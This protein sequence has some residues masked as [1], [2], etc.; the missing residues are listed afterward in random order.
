MSNGEQRWDVFVSHW[1]GDKEIVR[2]LVAA[3]NAAGISA[4]F[5]ESDIETHESIT[6]AVSDGVAHSKILLAYYSATYPER[7]ACQWELTAAF[8][9]AGRL[10]PPTNRILVVNPESGR[11]D[12]IEPVQLRD[13]LFANLPSS[14]ADPASWAD[15]ADRIKRIIDATD[16]YLGDAAL[17]APR[18][19]GRRLVPTDRFVGRLPSLWAIHSALSGSDVVQ[20]TGAQIGDVAQLTGMGGIGKSMLAEEYALRF[21]AEYPGGLV[22][23]QAASDGAVPPPVHLENVLRNIA[24]ELGISAVG[25]DAAD[26]RGALRASLEGPRTLWI[27]DDFPAGLSHDEVRDWLPPTL[28]A[29]TLI[30]TQS[31]EYGV[32]RSVTL[33]R[34]PADEA[35]RLLTSVR[36]PSDAHEQ[37]AASDITELL[38]GHPLALAVAA[39]AL[40]FEPD[41]RPFVT[42]REAII[43][44]SLEELELAAELKPALPTG[45]EASIATT[46]R[47]GVER[48][49][50]P[51]R[52]LLRL[53]G[54]IAPRP[55]PLMLIATTCAE[56]LSLSPD[57][58]RK[59][60]RQAVADV[61]SLSLLSV[62]P[63]A[64][65]SVSV[66]TLVAQVARFIDG[67]NARRSV[68]QRA[69]TPA[70]V[71]RMTGLAPSHPTAA[72]L[73]AHG[74]ATIDFWARED[75]ENAPD[76]IFILMEQVARF[77]AHRGA[78]AS[79]L[80]LQFTVL[81]N[82]S[83]V[84]AQDSEE[85]LQIQARLAHTLLSAGNLHQARTVQEEIVEKQRAKSGEDDPA[86]VRAVADLASTR[87]SQGEL[88]EGKEIL[89]ECRDRLRA[90]GVPD[91]DKEL[92]AIRS[93][94]AGAQAT[95]GDTD[96]AIKTLE[97]IWQRRTG[98]SDQDL[99]DE[100]VSAMWS[101][102]T[103]LHE[104]GRFQEAL[105]LKERVLAI[106]EAR[107]G[108]KHPLTVKAAI[109]VATT[110]NT[111][112]R[113][114]DA[115]EVLS[116]AL[117]A[118]C[119][120]FPPDHPA[121]LWAEATY[122]FTLSALERLDEAEAV[123][124]SVLERRSSK[125]GTTHIAVLKMQTALA[126]TLRKSGQVVETI[127]I[128]EEVFD[129]AY[130]TLGTGHDLTLYAID[131]LKELLSREAWAK[132]VRTHP[133]TTDGLQK[134]TQP[135]PVQAA[136]RN[137]PC[138]CG[139]GKKFKRCCGR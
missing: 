93:N 28:S 70:L 5:D 63:G 20:V 73:A 69:A 97:D 99:T 104:A 8:I 35:Y 48:L 132:I 30:T 50:E 65:S 139:S 61:N 19:I 123:Q 56:A 26:L 9:A 78:Y 39:H 74:R 59:A 44:G 92:L 128:Y 37:R 131:Q 67:A 68:L 117:T 86:T 13:G 42:Y 83:R 7:R 75:P 16:D 127:T 62:A 57:E 29:R 76:G 58:A 25:L 15:E 120:L 36:Q 134:V 89:E 105:R 55:I 14:P 11:T 122:G 109:N 31:R 51:G 77:D 130:N 137:D 32:G 84:L 108:A 112:E 33:D 66:H 82:F 21:A 87:I 95:L 121:R 119:E 136:G 94:L 81:L 96:S 103:A 49:S 10:G 98:G 64:D 23:L 135:R 60:A 133:P 107:Y 34:M 79:A 22:W 24:A 91:D 12:H 114:E 54:A 52:D 129:A 106:R 90:S 3:L 115:L 47:R 126:E 113:H 1:S 118:A 43:A 101:L 138:P 116:P 18:Q 40:Q 85:I 124:R 125:L 53:A 45:H 110:L 100:D 88:V 41:D 17:E 27:V 72:A 38:G 102:A 46:L 6:H 71:A 4:W 2:A 80:E 111:L